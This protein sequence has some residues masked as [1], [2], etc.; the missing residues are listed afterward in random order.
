MSLVTRAVELQTV[1][2]KAFSL[3]AETTCQ[4]QLRLRD[5]NWSQVA[6]LRITPRTS[7]HP[8]SAL[9]GDL[10][11]PAATEDQCER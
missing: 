2:A 9:L 5:L 11:F 6:E 8:P 1:D 10:G 7:L 4:A 3:F